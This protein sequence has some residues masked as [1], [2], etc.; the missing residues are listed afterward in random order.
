MYYNCVG[1]VLYENEKL[2]IKTYFEQKDSLYL[3]ATTPNIL[4]ANRGSKTAS[5]RQIGQHMSTKV[6]AECE[7][8]AKIWMCMPISHGR[9]VLQTIK[10]VG[11]LRELIQYNRTGNFDRVIAFILM[12]VQAN[13]MDKIVVEEI[14]A[15]NDHTW[16]FFDRDLFGAGISN[17]LNVVSLVRTT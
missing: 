8:E 7:G 17:D 12:V 1:S 4:K 13:E 15:K 16:D 5:A 9:K 3:M 2:G 14:D 10:S 6:K 11:I